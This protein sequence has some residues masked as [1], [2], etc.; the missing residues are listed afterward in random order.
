MSVMVRVFVSCDHDGCRRETEAQAKL[1]L[2]GATVMMT[3]GDGIIYGKQ[4]P[5]GFSKIVF[6]VEPHP[7]V[8]DPYG[9]F[10]RRQTGWT[11]DPT[12]G[13]SL[14]REHSELKNAGA[15]QP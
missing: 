3:R 5:P 1:D 13:T 8:D 11:H 12:T 4:I 10:S 6:F 14:C 9:R 7:T 2:S 15:S